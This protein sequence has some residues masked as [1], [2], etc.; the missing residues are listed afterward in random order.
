M[1]FSSSFYS[2]DLP[3]YLYSFFR[4]KLSKPLA[5]ASTTVGRV[6]LNR[7]VLS[8]G[9]LLRRTSSHAGVAAIALGSACC[10]FAAH[11][12]AVLIRTIDVIAIV[13][14]VVLR[15]A[16]IASSSMLHSSL[17][18]NH[19]VIAVVAAVGRC[20]CGGLRLAAVWILH[21]TITADHSVITV[22]TAVGRCT[23]VWILHASFAAN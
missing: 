9:V 22:M 18:A 5:M 2:S 13:A 3:F 10:T 20:P 11:A 14:V 12:R 16:G 8:D 21:S 1:S 7:R 4:L 23:C 19:S 15:A 6:M 17:T